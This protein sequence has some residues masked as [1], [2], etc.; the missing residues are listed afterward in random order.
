M[1]TLKTPLTKVE[2]TIVTK[3]SSCGFISTDEAKNIL[4]MKPFP[5]ISLS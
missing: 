3:D 5:Q 2:T 4:G 1:D